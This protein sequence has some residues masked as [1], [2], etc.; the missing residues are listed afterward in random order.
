MELADFNVGDEFRCGNGE[1]RCTDIG[2]RTV[3]AIRLDHIQVAGTTPRT[4]NRIEAEAEGWFNGP[5]YAVA[6]YVF[7]EEDQQGC[8]VGEARLP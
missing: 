8:Y 3:I 6:E 7:D 5:P 1:Y 4:L 2:A